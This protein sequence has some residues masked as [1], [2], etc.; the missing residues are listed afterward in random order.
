M[1]TPAAGIESSWLG[2][3]LNRLVSS[4]SPNYVSPLRK[5]GI[6]AALTTS[7]KLLSLTEHRSTRFACLQTLR[8]SWGE[9]KETFSSLRW[10]APLLLFISA[11][12]V[13]TAQG[14]SVERDV[15]TLLPSSFGGSAGDAAAGDEGWW[16]PSAFWYEAAGHTSTCSCLL[17]LGLFLLAES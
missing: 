14:E 13:T 4:G 5:V 7:I 9:T 8:Y 1:I 17:T 3:Q 12:A 10:F 6:D 16:L 15:E 11:I 2:S